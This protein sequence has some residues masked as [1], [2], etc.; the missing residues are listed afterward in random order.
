MNT[1]TL[2]IYGLYSTTFVKAFYINAPS[3]VSYWDSTY[4]NA[5][6]EASTHDPYPTRLTCSHINDTTL[7]ILIP[8]GVEENYVVNITEEYVISVHAKFFIEDFGAGD[9]ILYAS[10]AIMTDTFNAYGSYSVSDHGFEFYITEAS[11]PIEI[12][13]HRVPIVGDIQFNTE[14]FE[15]RV[16]NVN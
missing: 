3:D 1:A 12:S 11:T 8:E 7:Q 9:G 15:E 6:M 16:P 10:P 5:T 14:S 2:T 4:C 13:E